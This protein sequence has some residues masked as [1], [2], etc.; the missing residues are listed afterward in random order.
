MSP[1]CTE[2][3]TYDGYKRGGQ[4]E[5]TQQSGVLQKQT[6]TIRLGGAACFISGLNI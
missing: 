1:R 5:Q 6:L 4:E 2:G 3:L